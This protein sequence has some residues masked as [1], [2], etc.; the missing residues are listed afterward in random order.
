MKKKNPPILISL[1][2]ALLFAILITTYPVSG[3]DKPAVAND[4]E[5]IHISADSLVVPGGVEN[6]AQFNGNVRAIGTRFEIIADQ[7]QVFYQPSSS[8]T[9]GDIASGKTITKIIAIG[10]VVIVSGEKIAKTEKAVYDKSQQ[11]VILT[12]KQSTVRQNNSY[13]SGEKI[14]MHTGS[15]AVTVEGGSEKRVEAFIEAREMKK[16]N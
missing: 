5:A 7:L 16:N 15:D 13:I 2:S 4:I 9:R 6:Y 10:N 3:T 12:G 11:T 8:E 14:I 1:L